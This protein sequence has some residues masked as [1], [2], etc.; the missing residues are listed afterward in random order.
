MRL[1]VVFDTNIYISA[2]ITPS[3]ALNTW[4]D[5]AAHPS[6]SLDLYTSEA[7][8]AETAE[9]LVGKFS[10]S[11][12]HVNEF[13]ERIRRIATV[14]EPKEKV[15]IIDEDPDDNVVVECAVAA[16]AHLVVS[17]DPHVYKVGEYRGIGF[18]HPRELKHIFAKELGEAA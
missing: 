12:A 5:F 11:P 15:S 17:A 4:I 8:L 13:G 9:K 18:C 1:R 16:R 3:G 2:A 10:L 6:G 7:I 14:V